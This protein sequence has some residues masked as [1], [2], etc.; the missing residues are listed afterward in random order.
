MYLWVYLKTKVA[1]VR[2]CLFV[3]RQKLG[4]N[5]FPPNLKWKVRDFRQTVQF[6]K[7]AWIVVQI[8]PQ[9]SKMFPG[10]AGGAGTF[11]HVWS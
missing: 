6:D 8:V 10:G 3:P 1:D 7:T 4:V 9:P 5:I 2:K 11:S